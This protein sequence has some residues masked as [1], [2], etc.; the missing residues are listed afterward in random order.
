VGEEEMA[1]SRR[2]NELFIEGD[3]DAAWA[4]WSED[5]IGIPPRDWPQSGPFH[6]REANRDEFQGWNMVFGP[7]WT[8]HLQIR[9]LRDLGDGRV[10]VELEFKASGVESGIPLDQELA[11]IHH[12]SGGEIVKAEYF[13][14][15][16][17]ARKAA[18]IE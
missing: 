13:M 17:D 12:V 7:E 8:S 2:A 4:L 10:L 11:V 14:R 16:G 6:G 9:E 1:L 15:W 18:G 5:C 3:R